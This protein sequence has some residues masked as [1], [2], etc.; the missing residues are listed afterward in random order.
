M[1]DAVDSSIVLSSQ[2]NDITHLIE[3]RNIPL[4]NQ[5]STR[6]GS[7]IKK[8]SNP[9]FVGLGLVGVVQSCF[10]VRFERQRRTARKN[11]PRVE[12]TR[13]MLCDDQSDAT[14]SAETEVQPSRL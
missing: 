1:K 12:V 2:G 4:S 5:Q 11:E 9:L 13:Q 7:N 6:D 3:I 10:P 8:L 14:Q